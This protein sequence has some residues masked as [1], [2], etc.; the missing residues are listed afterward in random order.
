[1]CAYK[2]YLLLLG[3]EIDLSHAQI[4]TF[5]FSEIFPQTSP[6]QNAWSPSRVESGMEETLVWS[7]LYGSKN[8]VAFID[9]LT[10]ISTSILTS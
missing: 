3:F 2:W 8:K 10:N 5:S 7:L 6:Y 1:M 9:S 4:G